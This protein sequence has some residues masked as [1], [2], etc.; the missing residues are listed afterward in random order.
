MFTGAQVPSLPHCDFVML[1][2]WLLQRYLAGGEQAN[3]MGNI[4]DR[5]EGE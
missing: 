2:V 4:H 1:R 3:V 5:A